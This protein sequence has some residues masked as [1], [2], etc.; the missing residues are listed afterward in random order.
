[1]PLSN[2]PPPPTRGCSYSLL[3]LTPFFSPSRHFPSQT[4]W[5]RGYG[6]VTAWSA[7]HSS[8]IPTNRPPRCYFRHYFPHPFLHSDFKKESVLPILPG[9]WVGL[10]IMMNLIKCVRLAWIE[11]LW[12]NFVIGHEVHCHFLGLYVRHFCLDVLMIQIIL[13]RCLVRPSFAWVFIILDK[14]GYFKTTHLFVTVP[15]QSPLL[16]QA[17]S[18]IQTWIQNPMS[19]K[20]LKNRFILRLPD[21]LDCWG[22]YWQTIPTIFVLCVGQAATRV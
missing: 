1:M 17:M 8:M 10:K 19:L 5:M 18:L 16:R 14:I 7:F 22:G 6:P 20:N 15:I 2:M 13:I 3:N 12:C 4:P 21:V 11:V 9:N